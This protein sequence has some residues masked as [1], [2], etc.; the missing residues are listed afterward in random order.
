MIAHYREKD[1]I[2]QTV[3]EHS[4]NVS[5]FCEIFCGKMDL[6]YSG[7]IMGLF[8]DIGKFSEQFQS[9]IKS[10]IGFLDPS[11]PL[12]IDPE[13]NKGKIDHSTAGAHFIWAS[14]AS[15]F[16]S[17]TRQVIS[18]CICSHHSGLI[19]CISP[20]GE[21]IFEKRMNKS[22]E[23]VHLN[24]IRDNALKLSGKIDFQLITVEFQK[25]VKTNILPIQNKYERALSLYLLIRFMFSCL[26]DA[27]RL[28]TADFENPNL[29][30]KRHYGQYDPWENLEDKIE[31]F[32]DKFETKTDLDRMRSQISEGCKEFSQRE[33]GIYKLTGPTG[34]GKT[35]ASLRFAV[36]HAKKHKMDRIIY[37][38]PQT[39]II[40][41]NVDVARNVL[42]SGKDDGMVVEHHS[43]INPDKRTWRNQVLSENWDARIIFT[44]SVQFFDSIF[45]DSTN[46]A[47]RFHNISNS[48]IIFD[49]IQTLPLKIA[50]L[51]AN[52]ANILVEQYG[53][54]ILASTAT[55]PLFDRI[56][57]MHIKN[58]E[59][60]YGELRF[61]KNPEMVKNV[62]D[63][64]RKTRRTEV[65]DYRKINGYTEIEV[66]ELISDLLVTNQ[67]LLMICNTKKTAKSVYQACK[68][69]NAKKYHLSTNMC[70]EHRRAVLA[71]IGQDLSNKEK[72]VCISTQLIEAGIDIDFDVV[73]RALA[74]IDSIAQAAGRC[75]RHGKRKIGKVYVLEMANE[76]LGGLREIKIAQEK[77]RSVLDL[78]KSNPDLFDN[79]LIGL[80]AIEEYY[81]KYFFSR[82]NE[83]FY[84]ITL[85]SGSPDTI[86][87]LLTLN[88]N[89]IEAYKRINKASPRIQ[90]KQAF[91]SGCEKFNLID[92]KTRG[93]IVPYGE[94]GVELIC[95]LCQ[96]TDVKKQLILIRKAQRFSVNVYENV[97]VRLKDNDAV[98]EVIKDSNI[99]F[100]DSEYYDPDFGLT[101]EQN[102][103]LSQIQ[104]I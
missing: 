21:N 47:R 6:K 62:E 32:I 60:M 35:L 23:M 83:M 55:Q 51:F 58:G 104:V 101:E 81:S 49:E 97:F 53:C 103:T 28:D 91:M 7:K 67:N 79:D 30:Y 87:N 24:E 19:N 46:S 5:N 85:D 36:P 52:V 77:S 102:N 33:R 84:N 89:A 31:I 69:I 12:Y 39:S 3:E 73:I 38:L 48:I 98:H 10:S 41:Q 54:T 50:H 59:D 95:D 65:I 92:T 90:I 76:N 72:V 82:R 57:K 99:Y 2:E 43:N 34:I 66:S 26:I 71:D 17:L 88:I 94:D 78:Y 96:C 40:D 9:Y 75:N 8:H 1:Q 11:N 13:L 15:G 44:T 27:D 100:L 25:F 80:K 37:V 56:D 42:N 45:S 63:I 93:I 18:L 70:P 68:N 86:L 74:G 14:E 64:F 22:D 29:L 20:E 4:K 16:E 61:S